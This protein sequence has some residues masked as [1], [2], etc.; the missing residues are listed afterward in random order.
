MSVLSEKIVVLSKPYLGPATE[1]FLTRQ[2][3]VHLKIDLA[4]IAGSHL[5]ELAKWVENAA[6]LIMDA[7]KATELAKK[8]RAC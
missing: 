4:A 7:A 8:I 1:S 3:S 5:A 6:S 2:C